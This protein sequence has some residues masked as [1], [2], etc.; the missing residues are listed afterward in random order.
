M[1]KSSALEPGLLSVFRLFAGLHLGIVFIGVL[2][3][4][5]GAEL[6]NLIVLGLLV[7]YLWWPGLPQR[8]GRL[9]L[10]LGL[11]LAAAGPTIGQYLEML[12]EFAGTDEPNLIP[13][14]VVL[15]LALLVPLILVG[16]Q[17]NFRAVV[18]YCTA[19]AALDVAL[20]LLAIDQSNPY[21][22][23][24]FVVIQIRTIIY[25]LIGYIIVQLVTAQR[26]QH[27]DLIQ[28]HAQ[29]A[30]YATTLEQLAVSRER[31]RLAGELHDTLAHT[32]SGTAVQLEAVK[33]LWE[34]DPVQARAMLE[35]SSQ[36]IRTGLTETRRALQALRASP[37]EELGLALAV[38]RLA[39][40][41][42][43]Q[44]GA[45]L[46]WQ[47][48][49]GVEGL[50]PAMEQGVYRVAQEALANIAKHSSA[51]HLSVHLV[52]N[53]GDLNLK[54]ADNGCGFHL[55]RVNT[56]DHLGLKGMQER[57]EMMGGILNVESKPGK[58]TQI[59]LMVQG[60]Q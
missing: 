32:L 39:E 50:A 1:T 4:D 29:L 19:T 27:H 58:G 15:T 11:L 37:L 54:I 53:N 35:Q 36:A 17:Y 10:L 5:T 25:L 45:S 33:T 55:D 49:D 2:T 9:F 22:R 12:T 31:N 23:S 52:Q 34:S 44:T 8:L 48:P 57:A 6:F 40:S 20:T 16:W 59:N 56:Q 3:R 41:T 60:K 43:E 30:Q 38:R 26:K 46:A 21:I 18:V 7:V 51:H 14:F 42:A 47:G 28:A 24:I 13:D